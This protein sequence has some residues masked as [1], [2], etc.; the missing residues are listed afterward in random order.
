MRDCDNLVLVMA[1]CQAFHIKVHISGGSF[2]TLLVILL[3]IVIYRYARRNSE[4]K[5]VKFV[6]NP[7][8]S[9]QKSHYALLETVEEPEIASASDT[10][11][12]CYAPAS[13][14]RLGKVQPITRNGID[15]AVNKARAAQKHW[16][17]TPWKL[18][19]KVLSTMLK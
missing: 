10:A 7:P 9:L 18:R 1:F 12:Y 17:E 4:E 13:G 16:K 2:Q 3:S 14:K 11:I 6:C 8:E 15:R 19:R 5:P